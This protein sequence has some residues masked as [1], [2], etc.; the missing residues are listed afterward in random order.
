MTLALFAPDAVID[1][2][3]V[4]WRIGSLAEANQ[5]LV[6]HHYLG[7]L[8]AG[9]SRVVV[10]GERDG[11]PVAA[12]VWR[13]PTSRRLPSDGTWLELSRW[14]LTPEA[15]DNAGSRCHRF[16]TAHLRRLG[17]S[18]LVSY[19]DPSQGHTG[20]L[21]RACNWVWAPTWHRLRTPP[22]GNGSWTRGELHK[23]QS[24]KD[25][26][27]F[28]VAKRDPRRDLLVTDDLA[29]V[30]FWMKNGAEHE[31]KWAQLSGYLPVLPETAAA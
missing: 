16:A 31:R 14:C 9:G 25:R 30:R 7:P 19:S 28:H 1:A 5:L 29:A 11:D 24:V 17:A 6:D 23:K 12:Q 8:R 26:W 22:T 4:S 21:Y 20:A 15:G 18:T 3:G 10:L 13:T 27:V 2:A